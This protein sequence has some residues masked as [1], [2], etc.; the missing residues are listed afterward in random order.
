MPYFPQ[1][2]QS[3]QAYTLSNVTPNRTYDPTTA[4]ASVTNQTLATLLQD[5]K[6]AGII[7]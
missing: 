4:V 5:L 2:K 6:A 1:P 7:Q 3:A